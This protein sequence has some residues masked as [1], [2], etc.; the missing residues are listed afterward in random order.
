MDLTPWKNVPLILPSRAFKQP[1]SRRA[2]GGRTLLKQRHFGFITKSCLL[3]TFFTLTPFSQD[4]KYMALSHE[5]LAAKFR[6][7][8]V[9]AAAHI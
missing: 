7:K 6:V 5:E 8:F 4:T 2:T 9:A 1:G 3:K